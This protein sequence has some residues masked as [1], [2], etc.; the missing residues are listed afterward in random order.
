MAILLPDRSSL[1]LLIMSLLTW[2]IMITKFFDQRR[3]RQQA[4][5]AEREFWSFVQPDG[6]AQQA[7]GHVESVSRAG[8]DRQAGVRIS[9]D[10]QDAFVGRHRHQRVDHRVAAAHCGHRHQPHAIGLAG[11]RVG[12]RHGTLRRLARHGHRHLPRVDRHRRRRARPP[13]T[14]WRVPSVKR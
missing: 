7:E 11:A 9:R 10:Q 12:R 8:R 1:I 13:S 6:R 3:Q 14:R 5:E 4:I 2:F